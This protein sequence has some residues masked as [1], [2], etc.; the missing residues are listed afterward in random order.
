MSAEQSMMLQVKAISTSVFQMKRIRGVRMRPL[1]RKLSAIS[2]QMGRFLS[3]I[4]TVRKPSQ[5][6]I[7]SASKSRIPAREWKSDAMTG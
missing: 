5:G 7:Q 2:I 6:G 4:G 3:V 1:H